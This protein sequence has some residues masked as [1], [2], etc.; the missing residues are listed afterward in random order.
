MTFDPTTALPVIERD[1]GLQQVD[2]FDATTAVP[3]P[4]TALRTPIPVSGESKAGFGKSK[5]LKDTALV[6]VYGFP[7]E[8]VKLPDR[9]NFDSSIPQLRAD[10]KKGFRPPPTDQERANSLYANILAE[11][12]EEVPLGLKLDWALTSQQSRAFTK[13]GVMAGLTGGLSLLVGAARG[14]LEKDS[15]LAWYDIKGKVDKGI[16]YPEYTKNLYKH[17]PGT[18]DLPRWAEITADISE[19]VI[20]Y[21]I[22]GI[23]KAAIKSQKP[24]LLAKQSAAKLDRAAEKAA[25]QMILDKGGKIA[26]AEGNVNGVATGEFAAYK[27][28]QDKLKKKFL[29]EWYNKMSA[30]DEEIGMT[31]FEEQVKKTSF[32][33]LIASELETR[34]VSVGLAVK[35]VVGQTVTFTEGGKKLA[36]KI[37]EVVGDRVKIDIGEAVIAATTDQ[38]I[39]AVA[40]HGTTKDFEVFSLENAD[41]EA[42]LGAGIYFSN[43]K[44]E[45]ES[46]YATVEGPDITNKIERLADDLENDTELTAGEAFEE[47]KKQLGVVKGKLL[48]VELDLENPVILGGEQETWLEMEQP[49][50]ADGE[51]LDEEPTGTLI[52]FIEG[53]KQVYAYDANVDQAVS[54]LMEAADYSSIKASEVV[55]I[56]K[57]SEGLQYA[58][59]DNGDLVGNEII[60]QGFEN[61][62]Y[63]SIVDATVDAKFG[64]GSGRQNQMEG[65]DPET[66]HYVVFNPKQ[67]KMEQKA[68]AKVVEQ[69]KE[70]DWEDEWEET[71]PAQKIDWKTDAKWDEEVVDVVSP[72][73]V[74]P[75]KKG[76]SLLD[77][78][79]SKLKINEE[80]LAVAKES[81]SYV[82][83]LAKHFLHR[84]MPHKKMGIGDLKEEY[85]GLPNKYK[86]K[87]GIAMDEAIAELAEKGV[88]VQDLG[89]YLHDLDAQIKRL[90]LQVKELKTPYVR[91]KE[92]TMLKNKI[93]DITRGIREGKVAAKKEMELVGKQITSLL[94][95]SELDTADKGVFLSTMKNIKTQDQLDAALPAIE[96]RIAKIEDLRKKRDLVKQF[97]DISKQGDIKKLRPEYKKAVQNIVDQFD[98]AKISDAKVADLGKLADYLAATPDNNVP[99]ERLDQLKR[100]EKT[101]LKDLTVEEI[102]T[103]V[104]SIQHLIK[105]NDL[106]NKI[107][108][109]GKIKDHVEVV[110]E[111]V[112]NVQKKFGELD[113]SIDGLDSLMVTPE[114]S[115][116]Q[117][118]VEGLSSNCELKCEILDGEDGGIIQTVMYGGINA[119][120]DVELTVK[121]TAEDFF[122]EKLAGINMDN[123]S[124][125]FQIKKKDI[126]QT[127]YKI[128]GYNKPILITPGEKIAF[129][130]HTLNNQNLKHL[131]DGGFAFPNTPTKIIKFNDPND[132]W[133]IANS[134]TKDE[135]RVAD[136]INEYLNTIQKD[137]LNKVSVRLNGFEV[138]VVD[139]YFTIRTNW[140]DRFK[141]EL[142]KGQMGLVAEVS[143][144][145][146]G[147]FRTR[148]D[149][150]NAIILEDAFVSVVKSV[151]QSAA[152]IGFAEPLR[153]AKAL[154][155]DNDFQKAVIDAGKGYYLKHLEDYIVKVEGEYTKT[156][157]LD[158]LTQ[159]LMNKLDSSILGLNP[160]VIMKQPVSYPLASTELDPKYLK[161]SFG[162][163]PTDQELA[164]IEMYCPQFWDRLKGNISREVGEVMNIGFAKKFWTGKNAQSQWMM[165]GIGAADA[166]AISSIWRA[167]KKEI[168]VKHPDLTGKEFF[169]K[170]YE[171]AWEVVRRTQPTFH[172]KDRSPIGRKKDWF[173]RLA[174]KYSS[175]RNKNLMIQRRAGEEYN[176]SH[177]TPKDKA[178]FFKKIF[179]VNVTTALMIAAIN[180]LRS[181]IMNKFTPKSMINKK[182]DASLLEEALIKVAKSDLGNLY[183]FGTAF[184]SL[185]SKLQKG[186]YGGY[187]IGDP[188]MSTINQTVDT[189]AEAFNIFTYTISGERYK[190]EVGRLVGEKK[191]KAALNKTIVNSVDLA[192]KFKG[193]NIQLWRKFL[194]AQYERATGKNKKKKNEV[195]LPE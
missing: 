115:F 117:K 18:D 37:L 165:G 6:P 176:R 85:D 74:K 8:G 184:N 169:E 101:A 9:K 105:L 2:M 132:I 30:F 126:I 61:A 144:E 146:M 77:D 122:Q 36:G 168:K 124:S 48:K 16:L 71:I 75:N 19:T 67:V 80:M 90:R 95:N 45:V 125:A 62:G 11:K 98:T 29:N 175:Q 111:A 193:I 142:L 163:K 50:D 94:S 34:G 141:D 89:E 49:V 78:K 153:A 183:F 116:I 187:D 68:P 136:A 118:F 181:V 107:I 113:G 13:A 161:D 7:H 54:A 65:M 131:E 51:W 43:N 156:D 182:E 173:F 128:F 150:G 140:L 110:N 145:G 4:E 33:K 143:L 191:W 192:G 66:I 129:Y 81:L 195:R 171:R 119:G 135:Q 134:L 155:R 159:A 52:D 179:L 28:T 1:D 194:V 58:T 93:R 87:D 151:K 70:V 92:M 180:K 44:Y 190:P 99:Q 100:L 147:I 104:S 120:T 114:D 103:I 20:L 109:K 57:E 38:L 162:L 3:L 88:E 152:Y 31:V 139:N 149:T 148:Q 123:W 40:Y 46:N 108:V 53:L 42:D 160:F 186:T 133:T 96:E 172:V 15:E 26:V 10:R 14:L 83:D 166:S 84:I 127:P 189:I 167:V 69:K 17:L 164:E 76:I 106:K 178:K 73:A 174:T 12:G 185:I 56:L 82:R 27:A 39:S 177:K 102:E 130:L 79:I 157:D 22:G 60:R 32:M 23:G 121:K 63:D 188:V 158:K 55:K 59:D 24:K 138:A 35:P 137:A 112:A 5:V 47:A 64:T 25:D 170:A 91:M 72:E 41:P 21:S 154:L 86:T 97:K